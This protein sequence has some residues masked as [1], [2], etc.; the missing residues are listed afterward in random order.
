MSFLMVFAIFLSSIVLRFLFSNLFTSSV[1][2][3]PDQ[4]AG[5][6]TGQPYPANMSP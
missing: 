4:Q 5:H 1:L 3:D 6:G 2:F